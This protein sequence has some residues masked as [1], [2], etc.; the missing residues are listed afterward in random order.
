MTDNTAAMFQIGF[1]LP[2]FAVALYGIM[3]YVNNSGKQWC[4]VWRN[5]QEPNLKPIDRL[6]NALLSYAL[7]KAKSTDVDNIHMNYSV[8]DGTTLPSFS[9][10]SVENACFTYI[11]DKTSF[12]NDP[13]F[14]HNMLFKILAV[15]KYL[16]KNLSTDDQVLD[17]FSNFID[18]TRVS[19]AAHHA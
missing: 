1:I 13:F 5:K 6:K 17:F 9:G 11:L 7:M 2:V 15:E 10:S 14:S 19:S 8:F 3:L 16:D 18:S 4:G 12:K